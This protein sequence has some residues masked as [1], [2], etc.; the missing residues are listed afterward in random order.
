MVGLF[1]VDDQDVL[2]QRLPVIAVGQLDGVGNVTHVHV[3][4]EDP[5]PPED[6]D[7]D[8]LAGGSR[9]LGGVFIVV[10]EGVVVVEVWDV[11][12]C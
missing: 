8:V 4:K 5:T 1:G 9:L 6:F 11:G 3:V 7:A 2:D 12:V 10:A